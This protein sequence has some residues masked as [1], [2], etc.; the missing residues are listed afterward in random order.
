MCAAANSKSPGI[1]EALLKAKA[2]LE[3]RNNVRHLEGSRCAVCILIAHACVFVAVRLH[4]SDVR[5]G[6][7]QIPGYRRGIAEGEGERE[8]DKHGEAFGG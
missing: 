1:V 4:S 2:N 5:C 7:L 8:R 6:K 3:A